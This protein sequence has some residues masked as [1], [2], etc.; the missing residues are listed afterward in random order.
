MR[1][2]WL[3]NCICIQNHETYTSGAK[4]CTFAWENPANVHTENIKY[5]GVGIS[6]IDCTGK[7]D[8][9]Q[10]AETLVIAI[11]S[12]SSSKIETKY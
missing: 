6:K 12:I 3:S 2:L 10:K 11:T 1:L 7:L 8:R 4:T 5:R 9:K